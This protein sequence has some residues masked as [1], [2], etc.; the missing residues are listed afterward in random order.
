MDLGVMRPRRRPVPAKTSS[1]DSTC[2]SISASPHMG[3]QTGWSVSRSTKSLTPGLC[4]TIHPLAA[5]SGHW[6]IQTAR[7]C[8]KRG[9]RR[10]EDGCVLVS[11]QDSQSFWRSVGCVLRADPQR[12]QRVR[13]FGPNPKFEGVL[14]ARQRVPRRA[15]RS[16]VL[17][18]RGEGQTTVMSEGRSND[19]TIN[20]NVENV[21]RA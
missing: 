5:L 11:L 4:P 10:V 18:F 12:C 15:C 6:P 14:R 13:F 3:S 16:R 1:Q 17:I 19:A 21:R 7:P 9:R 2:N 8:L 20:L